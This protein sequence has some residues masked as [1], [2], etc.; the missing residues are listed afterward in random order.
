MSGCV[1][2]RKGWIMIDV[3]LACG[4]EAEALMRR[5]SP[6]EYSERPRLPKK[7]AGRLGSIRCPR[8]GQVGLM[9]AISDPV[10]EVLVTLY[11]NL[12]M[13]TSDGQSPS[14]QCRTV[15]REC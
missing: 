11:C 6:R 4:I 10:S 7:A 12:T 8:L 9:C 2:H 15:L 14:G 3:S 5:E 13:L 1:L